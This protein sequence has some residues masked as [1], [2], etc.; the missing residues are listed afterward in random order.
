[1]ANIVKC[2]WSMSS[3]FPEGQGRRMSR[4]SLPHH[5]RR[6]C[7]NLVGQVGQVGQ[8][9]PRRALEELRKVGRQQEAGHSPTQKEDKETQ[10]EPKGTQMSTFT[11]DRLVV[12]AAQKDSPASQPRQS[13][14]SKVAS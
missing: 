1:M 8:G 5:P 2:V 7:G 11:N 4:A 14:F 12:V 9:V 3:P 13:L 10:P 6:H